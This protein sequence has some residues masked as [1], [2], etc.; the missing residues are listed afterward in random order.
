[1]SAPERPDLTAFREL[2]AL[3]RH[4]GE[5]LAGFRRRALT[6][7]SRLRE[8]ESTPTGAAGIQ[9]VDQVAALEKENARLRHQLDAAT[10]R[11]KGMLERVRFLRQQAQGSEP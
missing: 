2:E 5:E 7:E 6:A 9:Q 11:A 8:I 3:V 1:M 10:S 4:L